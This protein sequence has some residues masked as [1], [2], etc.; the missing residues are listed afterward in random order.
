M[1]NLEYFRDFEVY[2]FNM[3]TNSPK[4]HHC[5]LCGELLKERK[6]KILGQPTEKD[7]KMK[8]SHKQVFLCAN[9]KCWGE[10]RKVICKDEWGNI[11]LPNHR[12]NRSYLAGGR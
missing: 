5:A 8:Y 7:P 12:L 11:I 4:E 10:V 1:L 2:G 6:V 3:I 9:S